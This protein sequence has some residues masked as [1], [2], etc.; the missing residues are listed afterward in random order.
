MNSKDTRE[1]QGERG[2][3]TPRCSRTSIRVLYTNASGGLRPPLAG[4]LARFRRLKSLHGD[5][6][7]TISIMSVFCLLMFT[8]VLVM[9]TN[10][11]RHV[12]DKLRMQNGADAAAYSGGVVL[13]RKL[14]VGYL[15]QD[16]QLT[17][18]S[19]LL[20]ETLRLRSPMAHDRC[21]S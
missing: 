15:P 2:V 14:R 18:G 20:E 4:A 13:A 12:D 3:S 21:A 19:T 9:V 7:G 10:V 5:Q 6:R 16:V 11:A 17:R 1:Q 8:M